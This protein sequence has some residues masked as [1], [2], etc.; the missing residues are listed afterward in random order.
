MVGV[1][2]SKNGLEIRLTAERWAHIVEAHDY[3]AGNQDLVLETIES[4]DMIVQGDKNELIAL[5]YYAKTSISSK[6]MAVIYKEEDSG[7]FIITAFLTSKPDKIIIK[8]G[9]LWKK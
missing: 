5:K 2:I 9:V 6:T 3:M 8:K 1:V 7:G 4:P